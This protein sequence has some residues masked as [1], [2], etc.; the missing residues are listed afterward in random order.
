MSAD[1]RPQRNSRRTASLRRVALALLTVVGATA[2]V[3]G[4]TPAKSIA[5]PAA[6][7]TPPSVPQGMAFASKTRTTVSLVWRAARD[8]VG[9]T[10]Y[11][12]YRNNIRVAT[13]K[14]LR[15]TYT[16]LRCGTSYTFALEAVDAAGNASYRPEATGS[17][18]TNACK[19]Q[20]KPR[21]RKPAP[22]PRP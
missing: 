8:D 15:Y 11:R 19:T 3:A 18:R 6:D 17:I 21:P 12:L 14:A 2:L 5:A 20:T 1:S 9:V 16:R 4:S 22:V 10:G 13:V 7:T